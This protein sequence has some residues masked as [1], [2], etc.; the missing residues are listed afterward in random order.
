M[1][2]MKYSFRNLAHQIRQLRVQTFL[3]YFL[4]LSI[5][6]L[7][8]SASIA[9]GVRDVLIHQ[10]GNS[11]VELLRQIGERANHIKTSATTITSLYQYDLD[12]MTGELSAPDTAR[13]ALE[14]LSRKYNQIFTPIQMNHRLAVLADDFFSSTLPDE[15]GREDL[16]KQLWFRRLRLNLMN[17]PPGEVVFSSTFRIGHEQNYQFAAARL[18]DWEQQSGILMV[19][20]DEQVLED[21]YA[22]AITGASTIYIYDENGYIVS[23]SDKNMVGKQFVDAGRMEELYG[24]NSYSMITKLGHKYLLSTYLDAATG[25]TIVEEIPS[26]QIFGVLDDM[27]QMIAAILA[28]CLFFSLLIALYLSKRISDPLSRLSEAMDA[29]NGRDYRPISTDTGTQETDDLGRSFNNMAREITRLMDTVEDQEREKRITEMN[30]LRAQIN[31]HFLYNTLFS[32]RCTVEIGRYRQAVDMIEAFTDLLKS[33]LKRTGDTV[34]LQEEFES[35]RKYLVVQK[36]RYGDNVNFEMDLGEDTAQCRV[37]PL[38]LQPLVENAIFHGLEA[39]DG[40]DMI[41]V[42]SEIEDEDLLITVSD[43]GAGMDAETLDRV[44]TKIT[45]W[46]RGKVAQSDSIGLA[47][48]HRR[49]RLNY[50]EPYGISIN[51]IPDIGTTVT[52]RLPKRYLWTYPVDQEGEQHESIDR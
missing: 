22:P 48:V 19:L 40:A 9:M 49:I 43:D 18:L 33:T 37:P 24:L 38:I 36:M 30:F 47:N 21:L 25:W 42:T 3:A 17:A 4:V 29:F 6:F 34:S 44:C 26:V 2:K 12:D 45:E 10:I 15:I 13:E 46:S 28:G 52:V 27:Y 20:I 23:H 11:R 35:T 51:S 1:K 5:C 41:V 8:L 7:F 32:I 16:E 14:H 31:P 50:G 39:R